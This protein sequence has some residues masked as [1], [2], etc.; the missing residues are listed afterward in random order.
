MQETFWLAL[1]STNTWTEVMSEPEFVSLCNHNSLFFFDVIF[2]SLEDGCLA[3]F[4]ESSDCLNRS[5]SF[6]TSFGSWSCKSKTKCEH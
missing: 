2:T 6:N 4:A 5:S 1:W 3:V